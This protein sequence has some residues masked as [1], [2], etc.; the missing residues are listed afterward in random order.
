MVSSPTPTA[1]AAP[2]SL[3][4]PA[5][6]LAGLLGACVVG[7]CIMSSRRAW[8][9]AKL[10]ERRYAS[11][12]SVQ[13]PSCGAPVNGCPMPGTL[14]PG[15]GGGA[16]LTVPTPGARRTWAPMTER[17]GADSL[18]HCTKSSWT[19]H[20]LTNSPVMACAP[21][22]V[23]VPRVTESSA[24][25]RRERLSKRDPAEQNGHPGAHGRLGGRGRKQ[26]GQ[27]SGSRLWPSRRTGTAVLT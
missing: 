25:G 20:H 19:C 11:G 26:C 12:A 2:G 6:G 24:Q 1:E 17:Y 15:E 16:P 9:S 22:L 3:E 13:L 21:V 14:R 8:I 18:L 27:H 23:G 7:A 10:P 4:S 5:L